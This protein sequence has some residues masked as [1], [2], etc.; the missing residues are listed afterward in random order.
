[1]MGFSAVLYYFLFVVGQRSLHLLVLVGIVFGLMIRS[2]TN[3][4]QRVMDLGVRGAQ[5]L[6]SPA[7]TPSTATF[8]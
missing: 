4:L 2:F 1:M 3:L 5:D 8:S 7:S 6:G